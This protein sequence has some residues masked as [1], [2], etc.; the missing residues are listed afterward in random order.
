MQKD[1]LPEEDEGQPE[2]EVEGG[3]AGGGRAIVADHITL[4]GWKVHVE[5]PVLSRQIHEQSL[6]GLVEGGVVENVVDIPSVVVCDFSHQV[7]GQDGWDEEVEQKD[8]QPLSNGGK[9]KDESLDQF[10]QSFEAFYHP[11]QSGDPH[12]SEN[13]GYLWE[14]GEGWGSLIAGP[15]ELQDNVEDRSRHN[16][17]VED[18]P[19]REEVV[20]SKDWQ[21]Q[22]QLADEDVAENCVQGR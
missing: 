17:E 13:P 7:G 6:D 10:L 9:W 21:F 14:D 4:V 16:K 11:K 1:L 22:Q 5:V 2:E 3:Y 15:A 12:N 20:Q 18:I 8:H 19:A